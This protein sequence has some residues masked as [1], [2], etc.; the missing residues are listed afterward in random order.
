MKLNQVIIG[1][2]LLLTLASCSLETAKT[3]TH[4]KLVIASD[5]L[6]AK[7][8]LLFLLFSTKNAV[9]ISIETMSTDSLIERIRT[10]QANSAIDLVM[11]ESLYDVTRLDKRGVF[12]PIDLVIKTAP[13]AASYS[14]VKYN[15]IG[16]GMDPYIIAY[17]PIGRHEIKTYNDLT[18]FN[19]INTLGRNHS[20][21]FLAPILK[22]LSEVKQRKWVKRYTEHA[23]SKAIPGDSILND[24]LFKLLP[25][26]TTLS[27]FEWNKDSILMYKTKA[28]LFPNKQGKGTYYNLRSIAVIS[29]ASNYTTAL[30]FIHF[31][32]TEKANVK[33]NEAL[34][35]Y[36]IYLNQHDFKQDST[37]AEE[38]IPYY[39]TI[40]LLN[41]NE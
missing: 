24:S 34:N 7:D 2:I 3:P 4:S 14:S 26:L 20:P 28:L 17:E 29:Q 10:K 19:H 1:L 8:T 6:E 22:N 31:C 9:H 41:E 35:T 16:F 18:H 40:D 11:L 36:S 25:V 30:D 38:L 5:Y 15:Y 39:S 21:T 33:L 32:T 23:I 27:D 12:H 13:E 37:S